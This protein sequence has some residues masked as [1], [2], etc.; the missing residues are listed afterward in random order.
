MLLR[1]TIYG[2]LRADI[3]NCSLPPG[4]E[5]REQDLAARFGISRS[6]I[7]D[8]LLKLEG[9]GLVIVL[10]R[11]GY[12]I[13]AVEVVDV[14]EIFGMR[15]VLDPAAAEA[16]ARMAATLDTSGLDEYREASADDFVAYNRAFHTAV[17]ELCGNRRLAAVIRDLVDQS[18]RMVRIGMNAPIAGSLDTLVMEHRAIIDAIQQGQPERARNLALT[19]V[20]H[21]EHAVLAALGQQREAT[22]LP[23]EPP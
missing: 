8:A 4:Q 23:D 12:R 17:A 2:A 10:P 1:D 9:D 7:R 21:A 16:A 18:D 15:R 13:R 6:P 3:L 19:H 20:I 5:V 22:P 14:V 11:Q